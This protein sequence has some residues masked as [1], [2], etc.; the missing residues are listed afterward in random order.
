MRK[1]LTVF[2]YAQYIVGISGYLA[3]QRYS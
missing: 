2:L 1:E 3:F